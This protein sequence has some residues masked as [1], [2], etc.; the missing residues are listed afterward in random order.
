MKLIKWSFNHWAFQSL[1]CFVGILLLVVDG[2]IEASL[3]IAAYGTFCVYQ[4]ISRMQFVDRPSEIENDIKINYKNPA[5]RYLLTGFLCVYWCSFFL[6]L[7]YTGAINF[8]QINI[9]RGLMYTFLVG[10]IYLILAKKKLIEERVFCPGLDQTPNRVSKAEEQFLIDYAKTLKLK[11]FSISSDHI[12]FVDKL[13]KF[14]ILIVLFILFAFVYLGVS[15]LFD[16]DGDLFGSLATI[17]FG[18][19]GLWKFVPTFYGS[20]E[21]NS[22]VFNAD[23][24]SRK[25]RAPYDISKNIIKPRIVFN[26]DE[27]KQVKFSASNE[28]VHRKKRSFIRYNYELILQLKK[29]KEY[30]I[31]GLSTN[32]NKDPAQKK[33]I[34]ILSQKVASI[35][36][37]KLRVRD[38]E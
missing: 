24:K 34:Y 38:N 19:Y 8:K 35:T 20:S 14:A 37:L 21:K 2:S 29:G 25:I 33:F 17:G 5:F 13:P 22:D 4:F 3:V 7:D 12:Y 26:F 16:G 10:G 36:N 30:K 28:Q 6:W 9:F 32:D 1:I 31:Y 18:G 11:E 27:I 23:L 15:S